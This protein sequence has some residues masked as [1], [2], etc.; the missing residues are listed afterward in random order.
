LSIEDL[1]GKIDEIDACIVK[2]LAE[3]LGAA[4]KIGALKRK[5]LRQVRDAAREKGVSNMSGCWRRKRASDRKMWNDS[6]G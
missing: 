1:R 2:L 5:G 3:R 4:R 6:T